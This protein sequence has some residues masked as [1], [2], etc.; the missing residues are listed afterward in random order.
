MPEHA[1]VQPSAEGTPTL[2]SNKGQP[3]PRAGSRKAH[4]WLAVGAHAAPSTV[5]VVAGKLECNTA[6]RVFRTTAA[7]TCHSVPHTPGAHTHQ[8]YSL[9]QLVS[10]GLLLGLDRLLAGLQKLH[11]LLHLLRQLSLN[12]GL[13]L[14]W[15]SH[16][17]TASNLSETSRVLKSW[18]KVCV[19]AAYR[20]EGQHCPSRRTSQQT[21]GERTDSRSHHMCTS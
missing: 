18:G 6:P 2:W 12:L 3:E 1:G 4:G 16:T 9:R 15:A 19:W 14:T 8:P 21:C 5:R 17:C 10:L 13:G 20:H 7:C 11:R